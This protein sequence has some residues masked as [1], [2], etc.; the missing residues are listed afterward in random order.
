M[1]SRAWID[2]M[3]IIPLHDRFHEAFF[4]WGWLSPAVLPFAQLGGRG[5]FNTLAGCYA[6]WGLLS[7]WSRRD[8]LDRFMVLLYLALLGAF[9][10]TIP[11][12]ADPV[13]GCALGWVS[14]CR[15]SLC[16]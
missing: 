8:R 16:S 12:S 1:L 13:G 5:L 9:L 10:L 2:L 7:F 4:R 11:G 15:A 6:V 3:K 14:S